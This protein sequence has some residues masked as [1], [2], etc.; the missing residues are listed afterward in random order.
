MFG[1]PPIEGF[2]A[3]TE[4]AEEASEPFNATKAAAAPSDLRRSLLSAFKDELPLSGFAAL[5]S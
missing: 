4:R 3:G 5:P 1:R 2:R